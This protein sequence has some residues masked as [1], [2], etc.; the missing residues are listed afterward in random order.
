MKENKEFMLVENEENIRKEAAKGGTLFFIVGK[1][2]PKQF[3]TQIQFQTSLNSFQN[4]L[5]SPSIVDKATSYLTRIILQQ[6]NSNFKSR[7]EL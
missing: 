6:S 1:I 7:F 3:H 5:T 2:G 4:S